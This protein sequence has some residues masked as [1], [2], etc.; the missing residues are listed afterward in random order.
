MSIEKLKTR[1]EKLA[2]QIKQIDAQLA[3]AERAARE[4]EQ[5]ELVK[6]IQSRGLTAAQI[7]RLLVDA[8]RGGEGEAE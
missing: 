3:K 2:A 7:S 1:R 5:R 8:P 4:S 6:L